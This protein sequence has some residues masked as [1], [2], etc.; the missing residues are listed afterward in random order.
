MCRFARLL[1]ISAL[2]FAASPSTAAPIQS[3][4]EAGTAIL[5]C[6][7]PPARSNGSSVTLSFSFKRDGTL[8]GPPQPTDIN[9]KGGSEAERRFIDAAIGAIERC[10]PLEFS[11]TLAEGVAGQVFT[12]QFTSPDEE[13]EPKAEE[14]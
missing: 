12:M 13:T 3:M 4:D 14:N 11:P 8:I 6:W 7:T 9:V 2:L 5:A 10:T 1:A